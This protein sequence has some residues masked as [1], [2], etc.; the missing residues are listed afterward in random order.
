MPVSTH[1][2]GVLA[3]AAAE[4]IG[5]FPLSERIK[6]YQAL[7]ESLPQNAARDAARDLARV[8]SQAA[9]MELEFQEQVRRNDK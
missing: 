1:T 6:I 4:K 3:R 5:E 8:L 2:V 9:A 7:G